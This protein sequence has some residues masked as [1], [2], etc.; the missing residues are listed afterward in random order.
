MSASDLEITDEDIEW[1]TDQLNEVVGKAMQKLAWDFLEAVRKEERERCA[2]CIEE[3]GQMWREDN[4]KEAAD[5]CDDL[6]WHL[7]ND[8][9][10]MSEWHKNLR[11]E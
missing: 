9:N 3:Y 8:D 6:A 1:V 7:R 4:R 11:S 5:V 10:V 2:V